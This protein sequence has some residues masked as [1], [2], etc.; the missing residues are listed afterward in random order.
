MGAAQFTQTPSGVPISS[1]WTEPANFPPR[2]RGRSGTRV[3]RPA[4]SRTPKV[5]PCLLV[6]AHSAATQP[7]RFSFSS[8]RGSA[9]WLS[10]PSG[11][12]SASSGSAPALL[13]S[14][15]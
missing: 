6:I 11:V 10:K 7:M 8:E 4:A 2:R 9:Q 14:D 15:G 5:I 13:C 1:P 3:N 12:E